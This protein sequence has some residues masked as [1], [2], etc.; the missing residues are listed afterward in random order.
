MS[1]IAYK[2]QV[3][4]RLTYI[5]ILAEQERYQEI[6]NLLETNFVLVAENGSICFMPRMWQNP[7][8]WTRRHLTILR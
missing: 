2:E 1:K 8:H 5:Q 3:M 6:Q 7:V 4:K